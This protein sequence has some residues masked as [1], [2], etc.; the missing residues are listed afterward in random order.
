MRKLIILFTLLIPFFANAM[1]IEKDIVDEFT[2]KRTVYTS[3]EYIARSL[4]GTSVGFRFRLQNENQYLDFKWN[5]NSAYVIGKNDPLMFKSTSDNIVE[6]MPIDVESS[7]LIGGRSGI[8]TLSASYTGDVSYFQ[9]N[10]I[11]LIR[12]YTTDGYIDKKISEGDGKKIVNL[13]NLFS[14]TL[15]GHSGNRPV[16]A[17]YTLTY[18]KSS[19]GGKSWEQVNEEYIKNASSEDIKKKMEQWKSQSSGSK[20]FECKVKKEK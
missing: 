10:I 3:W 17:N 11:R 1:K 18:L 15:N 6:F 4:N 9:D 2:G 7:N 5:D 13:Y 8:W 14:S 20:L 16:Y 12:L 19:N